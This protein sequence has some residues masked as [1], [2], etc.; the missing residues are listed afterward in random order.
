MVGSCG[1]CGTPFQDRGPAEFGLCPGCYVRVEDE[2]VDAAE[3]YARP[4]AHDAETVADGNVPV[5]LSGW[6]GLRS[7]NSG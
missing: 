5:I 1:W 4:A 6:A 7:R 2:L 3:W